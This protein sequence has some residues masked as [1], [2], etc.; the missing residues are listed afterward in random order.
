MKICFK[1][2]HYQVGIPA[3]HGGLKKVDKL[4]GFKKISRKN[5]QKR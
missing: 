3:H 1:C 4:Q 5:K 2:I